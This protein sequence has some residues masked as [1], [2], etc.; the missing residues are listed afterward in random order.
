MYTNDITLC[1]TA[2]HPL[3]VSVLDVAAVGEVVETFPVCASPIQCIAS[4]PGFDEN[5]PD[6]IAGVWCVGGGENMCSETTCT[7]R[8]TSLF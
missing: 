2:P 8:V 1:N 5:D 3:Q 6:V 7:Y 4:V